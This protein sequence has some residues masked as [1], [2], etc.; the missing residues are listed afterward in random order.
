MRR[1]FQ[2]GTYIDITYRGENFSEVTRKWGNHRGDDN[3]VLS[4]S[5]LYLSFINSEYT[6][7]KRWRE[8]LVDLTICT[9]CVSLYMIIVSK[10]KSYVLFVISLFNMR[11][12]C[13]TSR[14]LK[15]KRKR[16]N[17]F[18]PCFVCSLA[19][20]VIQNCCCYSFAGWLIRRVS[21]CC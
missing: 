7:T 2:I 6:C 1:T 4:V 14:W 19:N 16:E 3:M 13:C 18:L 20:L 17:V 21:Q 5:S 15:K 11:I 8:K 12:Y 10:L 9:L